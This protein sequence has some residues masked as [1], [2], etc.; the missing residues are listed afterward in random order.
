ME[1]LIKCQCVHE[2]LTASGIA[3]SVGE[4]ELAGSQQPYRPAQQG[5][6]GYDLQAA[7]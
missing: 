4:K 6:P 1:S 7:L 5:M 2:W 3:D